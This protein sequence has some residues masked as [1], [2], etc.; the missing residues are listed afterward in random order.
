M[1]FSSKDLRKLIIPLMFEQ[2]L[3]VLVGLVD[4]LMVSQSGEAAVAGVALVDNINRLIIQVM[5]ALATGGAVVC[6]QYIGKGRDD[7][8][9]KSGAQLETVLLIFSVIMTAFSV[10][11]TRPLLKVIFGTVEDS[12]MDC[13]VLYFVITA[14]SYPFLGMYNAG[15]A[16]FRSVGNSKV[17][18]NI[19]ILMNVINVA[20]NALFVFVFKWSV[21]GVALSTALSRVAAGIVMTVLVC[22]KTN[23]IRIDHIKYFVPDWIYIT[24]NFGD[25]IPAPLIQCASFIV[26]SEIIFI[27]KKRSIL[28]ITQIVEMHSVHIIT[29]N[30]FPHQFHQVLLR[31]RMSRIEEIFALVR[32]AYF[33]HPLG[34]RLTAERSNM[35]LIS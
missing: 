35:L 29:A 6:S 9:R 32:N 12:V 25:I 22:G 10:S 5:A 19:S 21:A 2:L 4:T 14:L 3:A 1:L 18:M 26:S 23:P 17:S 27:R 11:F 20:G 15:A 13:A 34:D 7:E 31:C 30:D 8:S 33:F 24:Y 28:R 16:I